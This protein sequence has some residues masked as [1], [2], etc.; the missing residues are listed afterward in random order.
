MQ[1]VKWYTL[2]GSSLIYALT[3]I[4][5][6]GT[7]TSSL[8]VLAQYDHASTRNWISAITVESLSLSGAIAGVT[9]LPIG[10]DGSQEIVDLSIGDQSVRAWRRPWGVFDIVEV[11]ATIGR[12][13]HQRRALFGLTER[14]SAVLEL[15]GHS[16]GLQMCGDARIRGDLL[17]SNTDIRRGY[18]E[19]VSFTGDRLVE[20][21]TIEIEPHD[22]ALPSQLYGRCSQLAGLR[23]LGQEQYATIDTYE[24]DSIHVFEPVYVVNVTAVG[25]LDGGSW[26]Q[27][28]LRSSDTL[29]IGPN[30]ELLDVIVQAP[31]VE[32]AQGFTGAIQVFTTDGILVHSDVKLNYPSALVLAAGSNVDA[33]I[34]IEE[35]ALVE[36]AVVSLDQ[37]TGSAETRLVVQAEAQ[38]IGSVFVQ[39]GLQ[40]RGTIQGVTQAYAL[41]LR[42]ASSSYKGYLLDGVFEKPVHDFALGLGLDKRSRNY[43]LMNKNWK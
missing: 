22:L 39:G 13:T 32:I 9:E 10:V 33:R 6:V 40:N 23:G 34:V 1:H 38:I 4:L 43:T 24:A 18:I 31:F 35:T 36:G 37:T 16:N 28:Y 25:T 27:C 11:E 8:I 20:G 30:C 26:K 14:S 29:R 42:T 21:N 5:L 3:V 15:A 41:S 19:G 17:I 2:E 7:I 12:S